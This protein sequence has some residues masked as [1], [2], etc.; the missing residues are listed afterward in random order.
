MQYQDSPYNL[1]VILGP[2][3]SGKT[4]FAAHLAKKIDGEIISADSR[5]IYRGMDLGTGKDIED[6][7]IDDYTIPHHL[8]DIV[9]AGYKYNVFEYQA[10]F[11]KAFEKVQA[12]KHWPVMCGGTGMYIE[13]VLKKY[14]LI[15]VPVN[16]ELRD[17]LQGKNREELSNILASY[18][19]LHNQ[20]DTDTV[21]RAIRAIE[22]EEYYKQNPEIE[23]ELP[24]VNPLIIGVNIDREARRKKITSRLRKRLEEG[25]IDE[26][27]QL[28]DS[29][30]SPEDLIYYGLEYKFLTMHVT[31]ELTY[32]QMFDKLNVAIH[33]FAKRQM[34]WFRG[35]ERKGANIHWVDAF[36]PI[37]NR[38]ERVIELLKA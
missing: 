27:K 1:I 14:K 5:Q 28:L 9:D 23:V 10:D 24:D 31:G 33:Q 26:V 21:K 13:S 19:S 36:E 30:V 17:S 20:T 37:E 3:A 12:N 8:L 25:M 4:T 6:Y 35:M 15:N 32:K 2:T 7:T 29:G 34:T 38:V 16:Q 18:K 11:F 22:I